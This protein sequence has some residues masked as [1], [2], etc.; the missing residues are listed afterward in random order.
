MERDR[1]LLAE[2]WYLMSP[3]DVE[4]EL[5]RISGTEGTAANTKRLSIA[6]ALAY[7]AAGNVP[8]ELGRSLRLVLH[9]S[10][11]EELRTLD[12]KRLAFEPD[13]MEEPTWRT[14]A[15]KPINIVPLRSADVEGPAAGEWWQQP[16]LKA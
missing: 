12:T 15:S 4:L 8:D 14:A 9:V 11:Q 3:R 7:K 10:S 1:E 16:D 6:E 13:Y 5:M 2:G